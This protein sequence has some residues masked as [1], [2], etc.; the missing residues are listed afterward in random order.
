MSP[1]ANASPPLI[2]EW[3]A[4]LTTLA[5]LKLHVRPASPEDEETVRAFF[6]ELGSDDLRFRFLSPMPRVC[7]SL[8]DLLVN[9]DHTRSEDFL[10]FVDEDGRDRM[11]AS[12]MLSCDLETKKAEV[13]ISVHPAWRNKGI[14]WTLLDFIARDAEQRGME[15]LPSIE[16]PDN[17]GALDVEKDLG[18]EIGFYPG[19]PTLDLV[20]KRLGGR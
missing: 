16:C 12:A 17:R 14:G 9:V 18:F 15:I 10:V 13:A 20:S 7:D 4:T 8:Y 1:L 2:S 11:V 6:G 3:S 5:G 19:D